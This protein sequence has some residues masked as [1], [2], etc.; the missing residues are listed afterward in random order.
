M[1]SQFCLAICD[2]SLHD[3]QSRG[4]V[5]QLNIGLDM[6]LYSK[7]GNWV[8]D[9]ECAN[10][11]FQLEFANKVVAILPIHFHVSHGL[12][13]DSMNPVIIDFDLFKDQYPVSKP[14]FKIYMPFRLQLLEGHLHFP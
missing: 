3:S 5:L 7:L 11:R 4:E 2:Q 10:F 9:P 12:H 14:A 13:S 8:F 1:I 6:G